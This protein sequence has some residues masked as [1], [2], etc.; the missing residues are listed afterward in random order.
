MCDMFGGLPPLVVNGAFGLP[1]I[2]YPSP[3]DG[4]GDDGDGVGVGGAT[5][6]AGVLKVDVFDQL[7]MT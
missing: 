1:P 4:G 3:P 2:V 7:P 6:A 5:G